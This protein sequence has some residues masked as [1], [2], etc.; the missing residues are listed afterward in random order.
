MS[1]AVL[2]GENAY[3]GPHVFLEGKGDA[4]EIR[5]AYAS[6]ADLASHI[7]LAGRLPDL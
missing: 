4:E 2:P 5:G 1:I 6:E 7:R 3:W